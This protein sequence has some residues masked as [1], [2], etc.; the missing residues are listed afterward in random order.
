MNHE[1]SLNGHVKM[2]AKDQKGSKGIT[3]DTGFEK[4]SLQS[5][6]TIA[7]KFI[8]SGVLQWHYVPKIALL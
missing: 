5:G 3:G 1:K 8:I 4:I 7:V 6:D 2:Y